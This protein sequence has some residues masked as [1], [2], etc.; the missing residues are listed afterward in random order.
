[1]IRAAT[2]G[3][4]A[5]ILDILNHEITTGFAHFGTDPMSLADLEKE[6]ENA[7]DYPW[8]VC[9]EGKRMQ[10]FVRASPWKNRGGYRQT[11][12]IGVYVRPEDQGQGIANRLYL[13]LI[14]ELRDRQ[15]HTVLAGIALPNPASIRLHESFGFKH[16]GTQPEVGWKQGAWRDV[17]YWAIVFEDVPP[18]T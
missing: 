8:L 16:I 11:C 15:F 12:E 14:A 6:F 5:Q 9:A 17:G 10:G 2:Q 3:D 1:M 7:P 4:L 13:S 18:R